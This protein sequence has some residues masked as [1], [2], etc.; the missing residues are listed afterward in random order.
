MAYEAFRNLTE[1]SRLIPP[2]GRI[3]MGEG[4]RVSVLTDALIRLEWSRDGVFEDGAT[5]MVVNRDLG[6][7]VQAQITRRGDGVVVETSALRLEYDGAPFSREGLSI[8]VKGVPGSQHNTWHYGDVP[9]GN[10][11]GTARTL[12]GAD[13]GVD[14][15]E[16]ILSRDGWSVLD[17]SSGNVLRSVDE[18]NGQPNVFGTWPM[19]REHPQT[20]LY[21]FG[22]G[23]RFIEAI[24]DF[25]RL[26]GPVPLL[27]RWALGNWWSRFHRY[28]QS[29]YL[30]LMDRFR[31]EGMPFTVAVLDMD[32]HITDVDAEYGS[33]WTGYTWNRELFPDPGRL[34]VDL[35]RR[36]LKVTLNEHPRDGIR[37]FEDEY[38]PIARDMGV[39]PSSG[40]A[41]NFDPANPRFMDAYLRM[42]DRIAADGV[43][44]WWIDWQ[45]GAVTRQPG[46]DPLWML[47]HMQYLASTQ[48]GRWPLTFSRYAGIGSHRYPI[49]FSGDTVVSWQSLDFQPRF[50]ATASNIGYGWWSH[51]IGGHMYGV[52]DDELEARWYQYGAFSPICRLHS[53]YSMFGGKEPWN[54]AQPARS[55][56]TGALR[57]RHALIPYLHSMNYRAAFESRPLVEPMYWEYPQCDAAYDYANE[58]R[59]GSELV[60]APATRRIE[61]ACARS[62]TDLW[63]PHG[64]WFDFFDG[65]RYRA[66]EADG[67]RLSV[68]RSLDRYPVFARSGAIVPMQ[69]VPDGTG[70]R[71]W[72]STDNPRRLRVLAFPGD[73]EF[74]MIEDRGDWETAQDGHVASTRMEQI[75]DEDGG[76]FFIVDAVCG[77]ARTA[78][79]YRDWTIVLRGVEFAESGVSDRR[80]QA[81]H[82]TVRLGGLPC[83]ATVAYDRA[84]LSLSVAVRDVPSSDMLWLHI[85]SSL[86]SLADN[87]VEED[88]RGLLMSAQM[89][90]VGKDLAYD[91]LMR[92]GKLGLAT[93]RAYGGAGAEDEGEA[94]VPDG[95][96]AALEEIMLR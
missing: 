86:I 49:G 43:D 81:D 76:V 24:D 88:V 63:L 27:P 18:V 65:R 92:Q 89:S 42:H 40:A 11:K 84:T 30:T 62:R 39:D 70:R 13:G 79:P 32:W 93:L 6:R 20:D 87:P 41:V 68:W 14:L 16:G 95:V 51:D 19:R 34:L 73:G 67:R 60:V 36:G 23:L 94:Y 10:L 48:S 64:D 7:A 4:W 3:V 72:N 74:V 90:N 22:Y 71:A 82:V 38:V 37:A 83:P 69:C 56:M 53:S 28:T 31:D 57:L 85:P 47:N 54:F 26:T 17:D 44:F 35:H 77:A 61:K 55:V 21:F 78:P 8:V 59:F 12:D 33:G 5:Q 50:T 15:G 80:G 91:A 96:M 25:H 66:D 1:G 52:R 46:L 45:Q 2:S 58:Y 75:W 9:R 29:E